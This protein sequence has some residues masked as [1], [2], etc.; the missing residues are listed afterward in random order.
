MHHTGPSLKMVV[1]MPVRDNVIAIFI[2]L[3]MQ[4]ERI[5]RRAAE[6]IITF[7]SYKRISDFSHIY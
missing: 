6:T 3:H 5:V 4:S 7:F 1:R 2:K